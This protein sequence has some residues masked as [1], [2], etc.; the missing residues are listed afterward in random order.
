MSWELARRMWEITSPP[1]RYELIGNARDY[2]ELADDQR[3]RLLL[4]ATPDGWERGADR[5]IHE[6]IVAL[7][8]Q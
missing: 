1:M 8:T 7:V 4:L 5:E 6:R 2:D 3:G